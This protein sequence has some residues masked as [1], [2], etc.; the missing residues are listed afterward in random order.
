ML[1]PRFTRA[2][3]TVLSRFA[4]VECSCSSVTLFITCDAALFSSELCI[5]SLLVQLPFQYEF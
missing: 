2:A 1:T 3:H 4:N 5:C